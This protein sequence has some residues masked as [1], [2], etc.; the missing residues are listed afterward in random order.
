MDLWLPNRRL[1]GPLRGS[2][3]GQP[4]V[5]RS[6]A[7]STLRS[8]GEMDRRSGTR[9]PQGA[10]SLSVQSPVTA[11]VARRTAS[12]IPMPAVDDCRQ[13]DVH[14]IAV[15]Q[16]VVAGDSVA[17]HFV[18]ADATAHRKRH[19]V[20]CVVQAG[21][22]MSMGDREVV[23]FAVDVGS[24]HTGRYQRSDM[25]HQASVKATCRPHHDPFFLAQMET[26]SF[27]NHG[28]ILSSVGGRVRHIVEKHELDWRTAIPR[29]LSYSKAGRCVMMFDCPLFYQFRELQFVVFFG[30]WAGRLA[31]IAYQDPESR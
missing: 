23:N 2:R 5:G 3:T 21:R 16:L 30:K 19:R 15:L 8:P 7:L 29:D 24:L 26:G 20:T 13:I 28:L 22:G 10:E 12:L 31:S 11:S 4:I 25:V 9:L 1:G 17:D 14:N 27:S 6:P 18:D